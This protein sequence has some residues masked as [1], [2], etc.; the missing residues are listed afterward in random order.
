M[1]GKGILGERLEKGLW[2]S[3]RERESG[4]AVA[5]G[6]LSQAGRPSARKKMAQEIGCG[7]A[8]GSFTIMEADK[9]GRWQ[10]RWEVSR[11][12]TDL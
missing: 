9:G 1:V 5:G 8:G 7:M 2:K 3:G 4:N 11:H 10:G 6:A 12:G